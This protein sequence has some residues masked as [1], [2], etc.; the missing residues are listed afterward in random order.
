MAFL[1]EEE[2]NSKPSHDNAMQQTKNERWHFSTYD[3]GFL[4]EDLIRA[5]NLPLLD[6]R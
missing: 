6:Y 1:R 3:K 4:R 2:V 5:T